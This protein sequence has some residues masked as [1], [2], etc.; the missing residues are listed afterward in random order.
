[1]TWSLRAAVA[2]GMID[3]LGAAARVPGPIVAASA[4]G[5]RIADGGDR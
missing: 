1:M 5:A 3:G 2:G 4:H